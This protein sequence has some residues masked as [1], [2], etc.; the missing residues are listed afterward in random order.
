MKPNE[1]GIR[2]TAAFTVEVD[3]R[4]LDA[5]VSFTAEVAD[6]AHSL[7]NCGLTDEAARLVDALDRLDAGRTA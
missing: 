7:V 2:Q 3:P 6:V 4:L 5:I 1:H